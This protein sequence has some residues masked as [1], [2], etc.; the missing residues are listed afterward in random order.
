MKLYKPRAYERQF[1]YGRC[2][3]FDRKLCT[4]L[5]YGAIFWLVF[6]WMVPVTFISSLIA[7]RNIAKVV[8]FLVPGNG[9]SLMWK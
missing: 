1:I 2:F 8:P 9:I 7:L 6:F 4:A 3:S 5:V